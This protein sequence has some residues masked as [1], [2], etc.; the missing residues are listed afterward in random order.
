M[1]RPGIVPIC[2]A[3]REALPAE[4]M[5]YS[6]MTQFA[7]VAKEVWDMPAPGLWHHPTGFGTLGYA[8]VS[9]PGGHPP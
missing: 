1:A 8:L 7:Y 6:D 2:D 3:L 4:T 9:V 5:V